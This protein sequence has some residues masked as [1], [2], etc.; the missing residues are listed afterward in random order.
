M[1]SFVIESFD[2]NEDSNRYMVG[3]GCQRSVFGCS[4][5]TLDDQGTSICM[6]R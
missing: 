4:R 3:I 5:H 2:F 1:C 6:L